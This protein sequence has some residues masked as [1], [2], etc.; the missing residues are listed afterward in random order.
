LNVSQFPPYV[1]QY[2]KMIWRTLNREVEDAHNPKSLQTR[3]ILRVYQDTYKNVSLI[4]NFKINYIC[5]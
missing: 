1:I 3:S 4:I 2:K 5:I